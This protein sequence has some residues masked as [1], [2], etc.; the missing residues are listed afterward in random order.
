MNKN[1]AAHFPKADSI[2]VKTKTELCSNINYSATIFKVVSGWNVPSKD[3]FCLT[4]Y[5]SSS[6]LH[7]FTETK[8][9]TTQ[10]TSSAAVKLKKLQRPAKR[11]KTWHGAF[12]AFSSRPVSRLAKWSQ[13]GWKQNVQIWGDLIHPWLSVGMPTISGDQTAVSQLPTS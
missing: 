12:C 4:D 9:Q 11:R 1:G 2:N 3:V 13:T 7:L 10:F 5:S 6:P 8:T